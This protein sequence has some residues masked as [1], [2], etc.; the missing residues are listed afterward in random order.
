MNKETEL[1]QPIFDAAKEAIETVAKENG[2]TYIIDESVGVLLYAGGDD[3]L[4]LVKT[5]LGIAASAEES[6]G[7]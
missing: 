7:E 4:P 6:A 2:Y 5:K 3:I 1:F